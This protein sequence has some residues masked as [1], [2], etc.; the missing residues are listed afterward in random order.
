MEKLNDYV[1]LHEGVTYL[2]YKNE[3][4]PLKED[5]VKGF[6]NAGATVFK[7]EGGEVIQLFGGVNE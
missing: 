2:W 4:V 6:I 7:Y 3:A 5:A 1:L